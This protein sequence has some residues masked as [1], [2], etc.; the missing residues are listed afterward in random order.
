MKTTLALAAAAA[1]V[2]SVSA[3]PVPVD[4]VAAKKKDAVAEYVQRLLDESKCTPTQG[5]TKQDVYNCVCASD[6]EG[7]S[8]TVDEFCDRFESAA[9]A[10]K[11]LGIP[12]KGGKKGVVVNAAFCSI[13]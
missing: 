5:Q 4:A 12:A 9:Q 11:E 1:T 3:N 2:A 8:K 7:V 13:L 10:E 6:K